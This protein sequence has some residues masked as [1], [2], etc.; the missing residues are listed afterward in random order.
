MKQGINPVVAGIVI[1]LVLGVVGFLLFKGTGGG[2]GSKAPM[3][4]GNPGPFA[5]G[6]S[7][8][9]NRPGGGPTARPGG[10]VPGTPGGM[11]PR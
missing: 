8:K 2:S 9:M 1:V 3:A 10:G 7:V 4:V 11:P 6:G 5:P